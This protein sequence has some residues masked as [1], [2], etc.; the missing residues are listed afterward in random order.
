M[1]LVYCFLLATL[2]TPALSSA[3]KLDTVRRKDANGMELIQ[4]I[5]NG[6]T[7]TEGYT[8]NG[9]Y[10]G[11]WVNYWETNGFPN[12]ITNYKNGKLD[13]VRVQT[14]QQGYT[15]NIEHYK[16]DLLDGPKRIYQSGTQ[17]LTE[18]INYKEG[19]KHGLYKRNYNNGKPQEVS[20]YS[21]GER[22]GKSTWYFESG[23]KT[24]E[25]HYSN[26]V[27]N[28]EVATYFKNGKVSEFGLYANGEQNGTWKEFFENGVIKAEGKYQNGKKE[29]PWKQYDEKGKVEKIL[30]YKNGITK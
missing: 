13:G 19:K 7:L 8:N 17:F 27:I 14:N 1:K 12:I 15:E 3:Q 20:N 25:Y 26:G 5:R 23:E 28:G 22:D 6:M 11:T 21:N 16:N 9:V 30:T 2:I 4:I 10:E 24:A 18:E 29:G